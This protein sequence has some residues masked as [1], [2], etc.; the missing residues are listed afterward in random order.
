ME[1]LSEL[2]VRKPLSYHGSFWSLDLEFWGFARMVRSFFQVCVIFLALL[3]SIACFRD[4]TFEQTPVTTTVSTEENKTSLPTGTDAVG[5]VGDYILEGN[6]LHAVING[7]LEDTGRAWFLGKNAGSIW[8]LSTKFEGISRELFSRND[9][10]L[11]QMTQGVNMNRHTIASYDRIQ[12]NQTERE[13][14]T[15][16]MSGKIYD[17]DGSLEAAGA[18]VDTTTR[19]LLNCTIETVL[20][21]RNTI[22][23]PNNPEND[24]TAFFLSLTTVV[25]NTGDTPL[26]I[27]TVNDVFVTQ[28]RAYNL[29]V[30]YPDWG[31]ERPERGP[32]QHAYPPY[33]QFQPRQLNTAHYGFTSR[34]DGVLMADEE[35]S[36]EDQIDITYAG[37]PSLPDRTLAP[38]DAMTFVRECFPLNG[39]SSGTETFLAIESAYGVL[40][41]LLRL[42]PMPGDLYAETGSLQLNLST[43]LDQDGKFIIELFNDDVSYFN[44]SGYVPLEEG[45]FFPIFGSN[46]VFTQYAAIRLPA[47]QV[48]F[49]SDLA[50]GNPVVVE[51]RI[52]AS[53]DADGN[54]TTTEVPIFVEPD[55]SAVLQGVALSDKRHSS[56]SVRVVDEQSRIIFGHGILEKTDD[57]DVVILGELPDHTQG[58]VFYID[59]R[60]SNTFVLPEG[61]YLMSVSHG[62]LFGL[63]SPEIEVATR[64]QPGSDPEVLVF[65]AQPSSINYTLTQQ[66]TLP[67]YWAADFDVR[68]DNDPLG[69]VNLRDMIRF[70]YSEDLDVFFAADSRN[71]SE[72]E[73][74]FLNV[75][76]GVA[77]LD[78]TDLDQEIN[79]FF[80]E[81]GVSPAI[82]TYGR[83]RQEPKK[84][85][86]FALFNLPRREE[87]LEFKIPAFEEDPAGFYDRVREENPN[88]LIQVS[89]PRHAS[90]PESGLFTAMAIKAGLDAATPLPGDSAVYQITAETGSDTRWID[91]DLLQLLSGNAYGEY[92]VSRQDWFGLLNAGIFK[93]V[94]GGTQPGEV[95]DLPL[96]TVRSYVRVGQQSLRD[97]DLQ[98]FWE[99]AKDG[100]S[101]VTNGPIIEASINNASYGETTSASGTA[102]LNLKVSAADW[103][104]VDEIRIIVDGVVQD[105]DLTINEESGVRFEG[106]IT[107]D[108]PEGA[109]HWVVVEA[110]AT[111]ANLQA[112]VQAGR[113]YRR[114]YPGHQPVAFTNPIF[115]NSN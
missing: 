7:N 47:R 32:G 64:V 38:G 56:V 109:D 104:P 1:R 22:A 6:N 108:L 10:G 43:N 21:V 106:Q 85:G 84:L 71:P 8:D 82:A 53:T 58:Q 41:N 105:V 51:T 40:V 5:Q 28:H 48:R 37:K 45:R 112:G 110:G 115:I 86:R 44:G 99:A 80:D 23:D 55:V 39:L 18:A 35:L 78:L 113:Q 68:S 4:S 107:L 66:I 62:P 101:F 100:H 2:T 94:T 31:F 70:A 91:F 61:K 17:L 73:V 13:V 96:G 95:K 52:E 102:V 50:N 60:A 114:A 36:P 65:S 11:Q 72:I 27:Y 74:D 92:L 34:T 98:T 33:L 103:V 14:A 54:V 89:R 12:I 49:I 81:V 42:N 79:S 76:M 111:L 67:D 93:P 69:T 16:A 20:E 19:A 59:S 88:V 30:P 29:F 24:V 83:S 63:N 25:T 26:P 9:D 90:G 97:N 57:D 75:A 46:P 15:L 77:S 3:S 87:E